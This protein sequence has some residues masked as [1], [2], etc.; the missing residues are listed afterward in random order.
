MGH[1]PEEKAAKQPL[2]SGQKRALAVFF[3]VLVFFGAV[4]GINSSAQ[5]LRAARADEPPQESGSALYSSFDHAQAWALLQGHD[6]LG[7]DTMEER[8]V[9]AAYIDLLQEAPNTIS[10]GSS[11]VL[12]LTAGNAAGAGSF[13]NCGMSGADLRDIFNIYYLFERSGKLPSNI[14]LGLD[15]WLLNASPDACSPR[16]NEALFMEFQSLSLGTA[17]PADSL[18][19]SAA[20]LLPDPLEETSWWALLNP[21]AVPGSLALLGNGSGRAKGGSSQSANP[22][23]QF[24]LPLVQGNVLE[25]NA[26]VKCSDGSV[27]YSAHYRNAWQPTVDERARADAG[28][29][30]RMEDYLAPSPQLCYLFTIFIEHMQRAGVNVIFLLAPYHPLVYNY[31]TE[32]AGEY[33]GFFLTQEWYIRFALN[34]GIPL[35]GSYNPFVTGTLEEDFYDGLHLKGQAFERFLPSAASVVH[36]RAGGQNISPWYREGALPVSRE[37][38]LEITLRRYEISLPE[39]LLESG[40]IEVDGRSCYWLLRYDGQPSFLPQDGDAAPEESTP[41]GEAQ[42]EDDEPPEYTQKQREGHSEIYPAGTNGPQPPTTD[43]ETTLLAQYAVCQ[44]TGTV[45]R[46]DDTLKAWV[47]DDRF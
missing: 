35:Y 45:F 15:P 7:Y 30:M 36:T 20:E 17:A 33:P 21:F 1:I 38:A 3:A 47:V 19:S 37:T 41:Q 8:A 23:A 34:R 12:Q 16:S 25:Q 46:L 14:I 10:L 43:G 18:A 26:N 13:F 40:T 27:M 29:F 24:E 9:L 42:K 44:Q 28:N 5:N 31:A 11:R 39:V 4:A 22:A 32:H 6:L 2:R